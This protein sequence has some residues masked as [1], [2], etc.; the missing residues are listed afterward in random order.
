VARGEPKRARFIAP[1]ADRE[2]A[3][4]RFPKRGGGGGQALFLA[5]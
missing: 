5:M 4:F 1:F 2:A 3:A